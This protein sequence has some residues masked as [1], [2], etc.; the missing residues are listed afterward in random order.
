MINSFIHVI[1]YTYYGIAALGPQYQKYLWWK[2]YLTIIQLVTHTTHFNIDLTDSVL[3]IQYFILMYLKI[4]MMTEN[5][6]MVRDQ[7]AA[8]VQGDFLRLQ[9]GTTPAAV[10]ANK[11]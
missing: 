7:K 2:R 8:D 11:N 9:H 5:T 6:L 10:I 3:D 4:K 1:M